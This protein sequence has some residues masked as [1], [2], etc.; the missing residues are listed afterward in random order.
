MKGDGRSWRQKEREEIGMIEAYLPQTATRGARFARWC[1]GRSTSY[2]GAGGAGRPE[3]YGH[4]DE[5]G[6]AVDS[7]RWAA[8]MGKM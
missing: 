7:G 3:G 4:G 6:A 1:R 8:A 2:E 5:G